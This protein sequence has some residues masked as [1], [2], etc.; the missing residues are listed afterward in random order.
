M[1][2][3][4]GSGILALQADSVYELALNGVALSP[5]GKANLDERQREI[6][7]GD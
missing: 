1:R 3:L 4:S 6:V 5:C 2:M 7:W